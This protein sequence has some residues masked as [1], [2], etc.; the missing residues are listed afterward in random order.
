M[1]NVTHSFQTISKLDKGVM[2]IVAEILGIVDCRLTDV[3][4]DLLGSEW[5]CE[6]VQSAK[7]L[8]CQHR[9]TCCIQYIPFSS[10][11]L[12]EYVGC[13]LETLK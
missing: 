1:V 11:D 2:V 10:C 8:V 5:E 6:L 13:E 12:N 7:E 9:L 3:I 4:L